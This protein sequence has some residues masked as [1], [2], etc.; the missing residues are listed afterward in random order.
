MARHQARAISIQLPEC[1]DYP[2]VILPAAGS[3]AQIYAYQEQFKAPLM[4][5]GEKAAAAGAGNV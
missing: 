2:G 5:A 3:Q 1:N 4:D